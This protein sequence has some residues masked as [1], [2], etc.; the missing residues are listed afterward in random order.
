MGRSALDVQ[1]AA[2][3]LVGRL[4]DLEVGL[5]GVSDHHEIGDLLG[6]LDVGFFHQGSTGR[7]RLQDLRAGRG[8]LLYPGGYAAAG[9]AI[10]QGHPG[11]LEAIGLAVGD[12]V[13]NGV[14]LGAEP[15]Q[16]GKG[17]IDT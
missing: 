14:K 3:H 8:N 16:G 17:G 7:G 13:G 2:Q 9:H 11:L 15:P 6:Q 1:Q 4:N 10:R 5:V 12:V